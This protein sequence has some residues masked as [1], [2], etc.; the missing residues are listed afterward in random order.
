MLALAWVPTG[1]GVTLAAGMLLNKSAVVS[2]PVCAKSCVL[3][4]VTGTPTAAVP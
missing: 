1:P 4:L 3:R 2:D